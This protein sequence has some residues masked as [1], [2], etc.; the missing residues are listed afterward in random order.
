MSSGN[1]LRLLTI[2]LEGNLRE[3]DAAVGIEVGGEMKWFPKSQIQDFEQHD[4][5]AMFWCPEWLI[6]AKEVETFIDT[7]YE[8]SLF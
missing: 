5:A 3:T 2:P 8:P 1:K 6:E 7:S 4:G